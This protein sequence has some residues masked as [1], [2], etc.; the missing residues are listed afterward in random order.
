MRIWR[1][2]SCNGARTILVPIVVVGGKCTA[3]VA[4]IADI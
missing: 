1:R 4:A 2:A 3:Y